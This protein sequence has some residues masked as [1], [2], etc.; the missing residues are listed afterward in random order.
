MNCQT[1]LVIGSQKNLWRLLEDQT[2]VLL[3]AKM[4]IGPIP[5]TFY[6]QVREEVAPRSWVPGQES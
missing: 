5:Y 4:G 2:V 1:C 6:Q 3:H